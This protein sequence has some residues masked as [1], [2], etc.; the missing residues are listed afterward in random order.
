MVTR[1][2]LFMNNFLKTIHRK[3]MTS[4][5][6]V[7]PRYA[8]NR[9][10]NLAC[11]IPSEENQID[12]T[13][14]L[15]NK[16]TE[17]KDS[18]DNKIQY[19]YDVEGNRSREE[20][21]DPQ[22]TLKKSLDF[23]YDVYNRL[24]KIINPDAS[25]TYTEYAYDGRGNPTAIKDPKDNTTSYVYDAL[26]RLTQIN[27]PLSTTTNQGY[28]TQDNPASVTDPRN[29]TTQY[30][31][32]DFGRKNQTTSPDT[33]ATKYEYDEAGNLTKRVDANGTT[34]NYTYDALNRLTSIDFPGTSED[35]AFTYDSTS[36]TY[37]KGRLTG[38]TDPSGSYAF[39]YDAQG[40]LTKEEKTI[41]SVLYTTE[42]AYNNDNNLTSITSPG[43]REVSYTLDVTGKVTG[44]DTTLNSQAK[45]LASS[46]SYLPFGGIT[47]LT[48]GNSL[49]LSQGYDN[50][51]RTSTILID[52]V[53]DR[54]YEYDAN[55]NVTSLDDGE[56]AGN[57]ALESAGIY[58]YDQGTNLLA[59]IWGL[60]SVVYDYDNN[61][62]TVSA[63]NRTFVYDSSNQ[64]I[65]VWDNTN[66]IA[67]YTYNGAG[68]RIKKWTS[69]ETRIFHYDLKGHLIAETTQGGTM[70]AEYVSIGDQL[71]AMITK[72]GE[73]EI[74]SYFHNDHLG[75]PQVLT[76]DSQTTVWKAAYTPFGG[77]E[78]SIQTVAN[79]FRLPGQ[80]YDAE[81]GLHYNYFRYYDPTT[82]RYVTPD[83]IGL[84]GGINLYPYVAG[85]PLRW[86][87]LLGLAWGDWQNVIATIEGTTAKGLRPTTSHNFSTDND[88][89]VALPSEGM[90]GQR[91]EIEAN[92][93][94]V[95]VPVGDVGPWNGGHTTSG[96]SLD[97]RYWENNNRPQAECGTD[98]RGRPTNRG[99]ID[100]SDALAKQLGLTGTTRVRW[101][102]LPPGL[103]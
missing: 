58:T 78:I 52:P 7:S 94:T 31:F 29:N 1:H 72:P 54:A 56:A 21:R 26:S 5:W 65:E 63:N 20:I 22:G 19:Q 47:G 62:N 87:D 64:L 36:V 76:N 85:N 37:G 49:S 14:N 68:Q 32:D 15:A 50:Q 61:G 44:V 92:G 100:I 23:T 51:Y 82:G 35:V 102:G 59:E 42:Y 10:R 91:V 103:P 95:Q 13:Y 84:E 79:P 55:G 27:Q 99:G 86:I 89:F 80:Y 38:R 66:Q 30:A 93:K 39:Y 40:N 45:T 77:A 74:V 11:V 43:G 17:I 34:V 9:L 6:S 88:L 71:L 2:L 96:K 69:S 97:D 33:G 25:Q 101:R 12:F 46:I 60:D 53:L 48:Y 75:T 73:T 67:G 4:A 83:P 24:K 90:Q 16:L 70:I 81:T 28:D 18:L 98:L 3:D 41:S 8:F 57:E